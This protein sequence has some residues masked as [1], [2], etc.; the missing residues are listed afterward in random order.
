MFYPP[1]IE[2]SAGGTPA[3]AGRKFSPKFWLP[4]A[5]WFRLKIRSVAGSKISVFIR[6]STRFAHNIHFPATLR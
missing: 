2:S 3:W 5:P 4:S 1:S 6:P